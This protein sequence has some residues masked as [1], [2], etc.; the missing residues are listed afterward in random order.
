MDGL[1]AGENSD[2]G[3]NATNARG[4]LIDKDALPGRILNTTCSN[5]L[6]YFND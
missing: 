6:R 3:A 1:N 4:L 2:D 5:N